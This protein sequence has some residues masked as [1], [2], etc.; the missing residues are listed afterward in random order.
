MDTFGHGLMGGFGGKCRLSLCS[1]ALDLV[2]VLPLDFSLMGSHLLTIWFWEAHLQT[3][4]QYRWVRDH[5]DGSGGGE[6]AQ[7]ASWG[8]Q[9]VVGCRLRTI[10]EKKFTHLDI[11]YSV[12]WFWNFVGG[13]GQE[14]EI[15]EGFVEVLPHHISTWRFVVGLLLLML[16]IDLLCKRR[17]WLG[18]YNV[19]VLVLILDN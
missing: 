11:H 17:V 10:M 6:M 4:D 16:L 14:S 15:S 5:M 12:D 1:C 19:G 3:Y 2:W 9:G 18:I 7:Q 13:G 8:L